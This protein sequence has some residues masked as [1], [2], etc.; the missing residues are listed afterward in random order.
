MSCGNWKSAPRPRDPKNL[1]NNYHPS[2]TPTGNHLSF[3]PATTV[4]STGN[5]CH[6][7]RSRAAFRAAQWR[8]PCIL[9]VAVACSPVLSR[10]LQVFGQLLRDQRL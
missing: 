3:Q 5:H 7:D 4:I 10:T 8:D 6:L 9:A 2:V 1:S